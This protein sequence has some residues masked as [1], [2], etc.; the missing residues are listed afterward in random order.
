MCV[1]TFDNVVS[2]NSIT[3]NS[4]LNIASKIHYAIY[5]QVTAI[6]RDIQYQRPKCLNNG[7]YRLIPVNC[8][9]TRNWHPWREAREETD[10]PIATTIHLLQIV[11]TRVVLLC[12]RESR[13]WRGVV[14]PGIDTEK[15]GEKKKKQY[16]LV[17]T[18][19]TGSE[20]WE[21]VLYCTGVINTQTKVKGDY[22]SNTTNRI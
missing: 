15:T 18:S 11:R 10:A 20:R 2:Y 3:S 16:V 17:C 9:H 8:G 7:N 21:V 5:S 12:A 4:T 22:G 19:H 14:S 1:F 13:N 6:L